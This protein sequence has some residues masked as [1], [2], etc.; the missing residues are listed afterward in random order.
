MFAWQGVIRNR[1]EF[2]FVRSVRT[3]FGIVLLALASGKGLHAVLAGPIL[4][5][6]VGS[7]AAFLLDV[8]PDLG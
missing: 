6:L 5:S 3:G 2:A 8:K 4:C 1:R 7:Q